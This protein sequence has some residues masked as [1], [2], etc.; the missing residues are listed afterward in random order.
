MA[1]CT[2]CGKEISKED[3]FCPSCGERTDESDVIT[4]STDLPQANTS[5]NGNDNDNGIAIAGF[6]CA[7]LGFNII[8][9]IL[10]AIGISNANKNGGKNKGLAI[11]GVIISCIRL[12]IAIIVVIA[13][14]YSA[15]YYI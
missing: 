6:I 12:V 7:I 13:W 4:I 15:M 8:G 3:K 14:I 11:A 1:F 2:N 9:I 5:G 10:S